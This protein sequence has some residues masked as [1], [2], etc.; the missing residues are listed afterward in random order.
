MRYWDASA[1]VPL[2]VAEPGGQALRRIAREGEMVTWCLSSVEITS[3][4]ERRAH[5]GALRDDDRRSALVNLAQLAEAWIEITA[6][7]PVRERACRL[8]A[9][10]P[11]RAADALQLAA[12]LLAANERPTQLDFV[13]TDQRLRDAAAREGFRLLP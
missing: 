7:S 1:I 12:A 3:A 2:I 11:L 5:E 4:L 10:H 6:V 13:C 8:L 9:V